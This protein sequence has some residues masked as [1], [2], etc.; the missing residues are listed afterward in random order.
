MAVSGLRSGGLPLF[1][2]HHHHHH[3]RFLQSP[4]SFAK[5]SFLGSKSSKKGFTVFS[6]YAQARDLFSSRRFQD[7]MEKLPNLVED[8]VQTSL[9]TGPRGVLR[10]AQGVQA[11][12]GVGQEWLTDVSKS[13]NSFAGLPTELQLGLLSPFYLRR[14]F[15]RM[16]ATYIKL[17]QFIASAP[18]L[19]PPEYVQEFQNCFDRAPPVPFEEI[20]SILR[21]ELGKPLESVYE[22]IDPTPIASASIA[23]VHGARLK[24]SREDVVIKVL[25]PGIEDILVADLNFVYVVARILEFLS[26]EISRTSLVGIVKDIRESMLEEVDFYKEAANI[27]AFR[28]YLETMGLTGN[29]TA[30]KVYRYCSTM[31]V[32]TMQRL[33]GVPLTDLDS[34]SSLVSNPE[35]SLITALNVWFGSLLACES[36]HADVHAGNL[37][38]LRDGR[39]GF[40]DF[41]IVGRISPKT[42]AAMEVFLGS[43]AI[44]DYDSMASSLIEMGATNQDVDAKAFARDLEKVFSSIKELDTEIVVATTTGTATN[45]TAVAANIV[46][47]ERQMNALFLD[48]VRV[49]ES[50]GLKFPR[51]F[52]LLLKQLLYFD[53]YTRLLAP[54]LNMLQDQRISIASN[55]RSRV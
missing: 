22:Y 34:I 51:E 38:L 47:D 6:R 45:A 10:L 53:R 19:F 28:R 30:P 9:N 16:G 20:E 31:K 48:V 4:P 43:I 37:W 40:L 12:L 13:A 17:G 52:A 33:Y 44:E 25:K 14:L 39:I 23:Q 54:N 18:T 32:L 24:G 1:H 5:L 21:K 55:S 15:E 29:A 26:P 41:G 35:T 49:S 2:H 7:S 46:V 50:Y 36:F 3:L 8:I 11:F 27:E 42:W